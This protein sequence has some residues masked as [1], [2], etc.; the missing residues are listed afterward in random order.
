MPEISEEILERLGRA[1]HYACE[2]MA[3]L[4][5]SCK[6]C[7]AGFI[8]CSYDIEDITY[9]W[10]SDGDALDVEVQ[11]GGEAVFHYNFEKMMV[12]GAV[13]DLQPSGED[14]A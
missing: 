6:P 2:D 10:N 4:N 12:G 11:V 3:I 5:G 7:A 14:S 13:I 8:E 1:L 9:I